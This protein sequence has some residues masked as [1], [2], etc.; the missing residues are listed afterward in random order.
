MGGGVG[1]KARQRRSVI[2]RHPGGRVEGHRGGMAQQ[3][4]QIV[5]GLHLVQFRGMNQTHEQVADLG[6]VERFVK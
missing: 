6:A 5:K 1:G 3:C 2:P 4:H